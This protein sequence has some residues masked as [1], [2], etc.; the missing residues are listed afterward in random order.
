[1]EIEH[2][3]HRLLNLGHGKRA[4]RSWGARDEKTIL[5]R[6]WADEMSPGGERVLVLP[7]PPRY[8]VYEHAGLDERMRHLRALWEGG[9]A[10]Y[11]V[12]ATASDMDSWVR[13][14][15]AYRDDAVY[16]IERLE[17]RADYA[18]VAVLGGVVAVGDL[19]VHRT[20]HITARAH[21][22]FPVDFLQRG[23][24]AA[25]YKEKLWAMR[26]LLIEVAV[27]EDLVTYAEMMKLFQLNYFELRAAIR[28][29]SQESA[30]NGEPIITALF[31]SR[32]SQRSSHGLAEYFGVA[33][34][35]D[36]RSRLSV[37]W[38]SLRPSLRPFVS[39]QVA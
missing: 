16:V 33:D 2:V 26:N 18:V 27:D 24:L 19:A 12:L 9:I 22:P 1:M 37:H 13:T 28:S 30:D 20:R 8:Q 34:D 25:A 29:L 15:K 10:G 7:E 5:L 3:H 32:H 11:A 31:C 36:E 6:T 23:T 21:G 35:F 14:P 39:D 4:E 38:G 17:V